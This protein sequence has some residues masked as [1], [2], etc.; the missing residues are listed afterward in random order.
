MSKQ[1]DYLALLIFKRRGDLLPAG[2]GGGWGA[3][4]IYGLSRYVTL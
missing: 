2:G 3:T 1:F 4:A